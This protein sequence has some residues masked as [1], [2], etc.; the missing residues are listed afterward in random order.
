MQKKCIFFPIV[1]AFYRCGVPD[2]IVDNYDRVC[3]RLFNTSADQ[4]YSP[5][6]VHRDI[7]RYLAEG[8]IENPSNL[9]GKRL[10]VYTGLR[11][12]LFTPGKQIQTK[13]FPP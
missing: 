10:Y 12:F 2:G 1:L 13:A 8:L 6:L 3:T 7:T 5:E 9:R 11:N 4:L